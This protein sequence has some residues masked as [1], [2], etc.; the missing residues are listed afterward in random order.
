MPDIC[1]FFII[2]II[3]KTVAISNVT[4]FNF[5]LLR[6]KKN[7]IDLEEQPKMGYDI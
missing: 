2:K 5:L 3:F 1:L 4:T 6:V 7:M